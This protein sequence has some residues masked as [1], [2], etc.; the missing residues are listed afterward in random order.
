MTSLRS[1]CA[2]VSDVHYSAKDTD[3][4]Q[5]LKQLENS[6]LILNGD[7][8]EL[9]SAPLAS[10]IAYNQPLVSAINHLCETK[11][12]IYLEGN[13]DFRLQGLFPNAQ[14]VPL[15]KQPLVC[16]YEEQKIY[17][18]H[19][20]IYLQDKLYSAYTAF[21]RNSW[22]IKAIDFIDGLG[23]NWIFSNIISKQTKRK[24]CK[25]IEHFASIARHKLASYP[26]DA[27]VIIEGHYHQG[28]SYAT[29]EDKTRKYINLSAFC[30][31][32]KIYTIN[33]LLR[34]TNVNEI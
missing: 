14:I 21:I 30:C 4:I 6:Q 33:E 9:L 19:G 18:S 15:A 34:S 3:F 2:I 27:Q 25:K 11:Q 26:N 16:E 7:I 10:S 24:K 17:I 28:G 23:K 1:D 12:V 32:K 20:D 5:H 31:E 29:N 13:H 22:V 8:F